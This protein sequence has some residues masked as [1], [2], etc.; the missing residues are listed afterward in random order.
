MAH[1]YNLGGFSVRE[2]S[3]ERALIQAVRRAGG[4]AFKLVGVV[5][6]PDRLVILPGG[7]FLLVECKRPGATPRAS[8]KA[9]HEQLRRLGVDV[10]V[11]DAPKA[12]REVV[13]V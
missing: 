9:R 13:D 5:G 11:V 8:Q 1:P 2:S 10:R 6:I 3:V 12:A 7:R 4:E